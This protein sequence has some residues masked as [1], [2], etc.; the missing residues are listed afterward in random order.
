MGRLTFTVLLLSLEIVGQ[1]STSN[2]AK[3]SLV[4][5]EP[6]SNKLE[7]R[8]ATLSTCVNGDAKQG[9]CDGGIPAGIIYATTERNWTQTVTSGAQN[10]T[11]CPTGGRCTPQTVKLSPCPSGVDYTSGVGYQVYIGDGNNSEAVTIT[12]GS[13]ES[14]YCSVSFVPYF[15]HTAYT[16][17]SASSGIQETINI[18]CGTDPIYYKNQQC[19][20]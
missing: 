6:P 1:A 3:S 7:S 13:G 17:G 12:S 10:L 14:N 8:V 19:N 16:I 18:A 9:S 15:L 4:S 20:P 5:G 2:A 11:G